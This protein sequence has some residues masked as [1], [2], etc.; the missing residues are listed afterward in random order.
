MVSRPPEALPGKPIVSRL[1]D[2][3]DRL[4]RSR[5]QARRR[6]LNKISKNLNMSAVSFFTSFRYPVMIEDTD[7]DMI[8]DVLQHTD[9]SRGLCLILN[10]PGGLAIAAE[11]I[12]HICRT[13]SNGRFCVLVPRRAKSA[14]TMIALGATEIIMGETSELGPIGTQVFKID[15][16]GLLQQY[17][18]YSI[19]KSYDDLMQK[20][21][22]T[23]GR[24]EPFLLQLDKFDAA[25]VEDLRAAEDLAKDIAVRWLKE[26]MMQNYDETDIER[27]IDIFLKPEETKA[28]S[29]PIF[30]DEV[31]KTD[32][33]VSLIKVADPFW[34]TISELYQRTDQLVSNEACEVVEFTQHLFMLPAPSSPEGGADLSSSS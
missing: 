25:E 34:D 30:Y 10:S 11:R 5:Q 26:D 3:E 20:A 28:H 15:Q 19:I 23:E 22:K 27:K 18:A 14:A 7:A 16:H 1:R 31:R 4:N 12:V 13:Y 17:S 24:P 29:R 21:E 33:N 8:E 9:L 2:E 32:V 6:L